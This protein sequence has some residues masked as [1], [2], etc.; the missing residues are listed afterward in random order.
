MVHVEQSKI[1]ITRIVFQTLNH[2][3]VLEQQELLKLPEKIL[4]IKRSKN[5]MFTDRQTDRQT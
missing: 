5:M 3:E 2:M 4:D 1:S